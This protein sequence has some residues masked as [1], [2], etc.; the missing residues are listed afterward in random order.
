MGICRQILESLPEWWSL[1]PDQSMI[2]TG[3]GEGEQQSVCA[4]SASGD[5]AVV[6]LARPCKVVLDAAIA[7][8]PAQLVNPTTGERTAARPHGQSVKTPDG[9]EDAVVLFQR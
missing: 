2:L 3:E 4:R 1:V 6:Y 5:W 7:A 9:W 8:L